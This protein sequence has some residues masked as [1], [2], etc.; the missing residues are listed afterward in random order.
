[1]VF[2]M[3]GS[4]MLL[5][6]WWASL[7][8]GCVVVVLMA[9]CGSS[10]KSSVGEGSDPSGAAVVVGAIE[11]ESGSSIGVANSDVSSALAAWAVWVNGHGGLSGHEVKLVALDDQG[12]PSDS[13]SD[14]QTLI[15]DHAVAIVD[16]TNLDTTWAAKVAAAGIPVVCGEEVANGFTCESNPDFFSPGGTVLATLYGVFVAAKQAGVSDVGSVYCT[17]LAACK[18]AIPLYASYA[19]E[20]GLRSSTPL[21]ASESAPSYTAQ[22]VTLAQDKA[23]AVFPAGPPSVKLAADCAQQGY[24]PVYM[25]AAGT[26]ERSFLSDADLNGTVGAVPDLPWSVTT[27][28]AATTFHAAEG[29]VLAK[30]FSPYNVDTA[31]AAGLLIEAAGGQ[32]GAHPSAAGVLAGLYSLHADTL[33]GFS[34]PLSF[35][36]GKATAVDGFYLVTIKNGAWYAPDGATYRTQPS[37]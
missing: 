31:W 22:C 36:K 21:A 2:V 13:E 37:S 20:L 32:L 5:R 33:G 6:R 11:T 9:G 24:H 34:P 23:N 19:R 17:E 4:E 15:G 7:G 18:E 26:W 12:L 30:A 10:S 35:T 1:M 8:A 3:R 27:G 28:A 25:E 16:G 14:A 29:S